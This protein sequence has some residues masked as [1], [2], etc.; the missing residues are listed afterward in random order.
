M[1]PTGLLVITVSLTLTL[2]GFGAAGSTIAQDPAV[3][4][5]LAQLD[6]QLAVVMKER[7]LP[8][9]SAGVIYDREL[10][11][12]KG[13][14]YADLERHIPADADSIYEIGSVTKLFNAVM[15]MK[16]RDAGKLSLDD[17][18]EKYLP[19]FKI[20]SGF[21]DTRPPTFRQ[22]VSHVSGLP[23]EYGFDVGESG[24][25]QQFPA[26]VVLAGIK[27]KEMQY[28]AYTGF[29]YSNLGIYII[30][31]ALQRIA[32]EPYTQYM[33]RNVFDPL[34]MRSTGWEYT[35]AMRPHRAIGYMAA[36]PD[37]SR[38]VAPLFVPGDFGVSAGGIQSSV[39]D[40]A[41]FVS[42][43]FGEGPA[44]GEQILGGTTLREMRSSLVPAENW[45]WGYGIGWEVEKYP[46]HVGIC[47]S[48]GTL[49][50]ASKVRAVPD[51]KLGLVVLINQD[52]D[53][54]ELSRKLVEGL[55]PSFEQVARQ[56]ALQEKPPL[57]ADAAKYAGHYSC[58]FGILDIFI[59]DGRLVLITTETDGSKGAPWMLQARE[60]GTL[61]IRSGSKDFDGQVITFRPAT[62]DESASIELLGVKF[63]RKGEASVANTP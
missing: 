48:G 19:E 11:W 45:L 25:L 29:H 9:L 54:D 61:L 53:S 44:G 40:M 15:L 6:A 16:L 39:R 24:H 31:Q 18:I 60:D 38:E 56:R 34:G 32:G 37:G 57:P 23:R 55:I 21:Q 8:G 47:H 27:D 4:A 10:V 26:A 17:P 59:L 49:G 5:A 7:N 42:L 20:R 22:V 30:G 46:N 62:G 36:K 35:D 51:L 14:G 12:A 58:Q 41:K 2:V 28:P 43:Q 63:P 13:Y 50:F 3:S 33:Q 1:K 52:T